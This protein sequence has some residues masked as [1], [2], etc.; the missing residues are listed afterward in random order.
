MSRLSA[1]L[2]ASALLV[3]GCSGDAADSSGAPTSVPER[4]GRAEAIDACELAGKRQ[5]ERALQRTLRVVGRRAEAP[6][7]PTETCLWGS[8]FSVPVLEVQVTPGPVAADTFEAAFGPDAGGE[9]DRVK[10]LGEAA[11]A[12]TGMTD[13]T[14]QVLA[15]GVVL[16]LEA[17]DDPGNSLPESALTT[18][19]GAAVDALPANPQLPAG[20]SGAACARIKDG[21]IAEVLG[22]EPEL[23]RM[24]RG[25]DGAAL[26]S[27]SALPGNLVVTVRTNPTQVTNFRANLSP[28]LYTE[29]KG[30]GVETYSQN[31]QAGDLLMFVGESLVEVETLPAEGLPAEDTPTSESE[32]RL[33]RALVRALGGDP[34][35][36]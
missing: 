24:H 14:L 4:S 35:P 5:V 36:E 20:S 33:A 27:W 11:Y 30:T 18:V 10:G 12:R 21:L 34:A 31:Q 23:R 19:A 25:G 6:T 8:E 2:A 7:L 17:K 1:V 13:R 29:V 32:M 15:E 3:V 22:A 16:T 26:C 28:R 9:P